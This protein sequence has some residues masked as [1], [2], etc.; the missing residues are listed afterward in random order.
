MSLL[1]IKEAIVVEGKY[2]VQRLQTVVDTVVVSTGGFRLFRSSETVSLLRQLAE[3]QGLIVLTDSDTAGFVIRDYISGAISIGRVLH[4]YIPEIAG[5]ERR[6][7]AAG[8]EGLLGVEGIDIDCIKQVL[9]RAG[10]TTEQG[11]LHTISF[12]TKARLFEDG[13]TGRTNSAEKRRSM[14]RQ[15][16][17]PEK[18]SVNRF[19]EVINAVLTEEQYINILAASNQKSDNLY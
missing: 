7:H 4:A 12:L 6:K 2:D 10:A 18:L 15:L 3:K 5:K 16:N 8:K 1:K 14:L 17:F 11:S 19:L 9:L 13:L